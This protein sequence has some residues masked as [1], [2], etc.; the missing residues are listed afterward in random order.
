MNKWCRMIALVWVLGLAACGGGSGS[1]G[2]INSENALIDHVRQ[3]GT[4]AESKGAA[5]CATNSANAT[6]PGGQRAEVVGGTP[7]PLASSTPA[8]TGG[9]LSPTPAPSGGGEPTPSSSSVSTPGASPSPMPRTARVIVEGFG[10]GAA[11]C[12]AARAK[13]SDGSWQ[14]G[15]LVTVDGGTDP[16]TFFIPFNVAEPSEAVLLCFESVPTEL[17]TEVEELTTTNPTVV[18]VLP[19]S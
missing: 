15:P 9:G 8:P 6:A 11:C 13:G 17:P 10:P 14:V 16:H 12:V 3:T 7:T 5:F 2:L 18:F 19:T 4:C 1:T